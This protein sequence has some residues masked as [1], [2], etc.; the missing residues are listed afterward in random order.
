MACG[1]EIQVTTLVL[2]DPTV[3]VWRLG[4]AGYQESGELL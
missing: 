3:W 2:K 1:V 4:A